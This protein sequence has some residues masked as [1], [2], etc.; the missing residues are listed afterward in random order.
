VAGESDAGGVICPHSSVLWEF[1]PQGSR[2]GSPSLSSAVAQLALDAFGSLPNLT[3]SRHAIG[4]ELEAL[5]VTT[6]A[7]ASA[8]PAVTATSVRIT[9]FI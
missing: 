9:G 4:K 6:K 2:L 3:P 5:T 1:V 7:I 8:I